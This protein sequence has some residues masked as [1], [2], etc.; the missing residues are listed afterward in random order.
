MLWRRPWDGDRSCRSWDGSLLYT[1]VHAEQKGITS[2]ATTP[3]TVA[4]PF[5]HQNVK[6][7][8]LLPNSA[9]DAGAAD[10]WDIGR[11]TPYVPIGEKE[12]AR[13]MV[14]RKEEKGSMARKE[15][16]RMVEKEGWIQFNSERWRLRLRGWWDFHSMR[17]INFWR[18]S[19]P[20][21]RRPQKLPCLLDLLLYYKDLLL[22]YQQRHRLL[23]RRHHQRR[24]CH[25]RNTV[26]KERHQCLRQHGELLRLWKS[27]GERT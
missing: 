11:E 14:E 21:C 23:H 1:K 9:A 18:K 16:P 15:T 26:N 13:A 17:S 27:P 12:R 4:H 5:Q 22:Y 7:K 24:S 25:H 2:P 10:K 20:S 6:R 19:L 8:S 3:T